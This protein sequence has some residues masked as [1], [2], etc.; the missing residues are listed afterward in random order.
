MFGTSRARA[1][2]CFKST[3]A[4]KNFLNKPHCKQV[5]GL[6]LLFYLPF[7]F[8]PHIFPSLA[9]PRIDPVIK[10]P[11]SCVSNRKSSLDCLLSIF[12][13]HLSHFNS[14]ASDTTSHANVER[15]N[16]LPNV[17]HIASSLINTLNNGQSLLANRLYR[18]RHVS[19]L[20]FSG[21]S[22]G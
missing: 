2:S 4:S 8:V 18:S 5:T 11:C 7:L 17:T 15:T 14:I 1:S 3:S 12:Q 19:F 16:S 9:L 21:E 6:L 22:L 10:F 13:F 20:K